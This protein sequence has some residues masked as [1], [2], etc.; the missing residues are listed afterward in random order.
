[1]QSKNLPAS[2]ARFAENNPS[3]LHNILWTRKG[4]PFR[5]VSK[6]RAIIAPVRITPKKTTPSPENTH[7]G[8]RS[9]FKAIDNIL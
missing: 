9:Q 7:F 3:P 2:S 5:A 6:C 4:N 8:T 1:M